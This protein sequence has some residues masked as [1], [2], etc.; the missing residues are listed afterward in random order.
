MPFRLR[1]GAQVA[2]PQFHFITGQSPATGKQKAGNEG[3]E[4]HPTSR[5]DR[6]FLYQA[7]NH[8][9]L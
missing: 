6:V 5:A 9:G 2:K 1:R 7:F 8:E 3:K 4:K